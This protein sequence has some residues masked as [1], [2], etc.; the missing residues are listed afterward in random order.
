MSEYAAGEDQMKEEV[1]GLDPDPEEEDLN[2]D[3]GTAGGNPF[4]EVDEVDD[5]KPQRDAKDDQ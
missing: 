5:G 3:E 2:E 1:P 4:A